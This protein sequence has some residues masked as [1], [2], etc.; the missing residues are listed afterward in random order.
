LAIE[1]GGFARSRLAS[2]K[3]ILTIVNFFYIIAMIMIINIDLFIEKIKWKKRRAI[4]EYNSS[5]VDK[6]YVNLRMITR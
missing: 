2:T 3:Q 5:E 6:K 4:N 1:V